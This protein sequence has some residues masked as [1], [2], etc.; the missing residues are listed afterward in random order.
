MFGGLC[1]LAN[2]HMCCGVN[3]RDLMLR[4]GNTL[5]SDSL[6]K[7]N[8]RPMDFTG[9]TIKS[10]IYVAPEGTQTEEALREWVLLAVHFAR[11]LPPK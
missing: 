8:T 2:G 10:M 3:G 9:K 7:K 5:A 1:F 6:L 4:I 11:S